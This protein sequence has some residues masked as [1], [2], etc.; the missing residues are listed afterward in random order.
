MPAKHTRTRRDHYSIRQSGLRN[1]SWY[2]PEIESPSDDL[3]SQDS[4]SENGETDF[5]GFDS[6]SITGVPNLGP[7]GDLQEG[8]VYSVGAGEV[9]PQTPKQAPELPLTPLAEEGSPTS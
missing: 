2:G 5:N 9:S 6:L 8:I 1:R 4:V 3:P 7:K